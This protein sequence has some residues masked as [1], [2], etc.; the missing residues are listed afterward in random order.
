MNKTRL[1]NLTTIL[2]LVLGLCFQN[3][4]FAQEKV[5]LE[6]RI[7]GS[8]FKALAKA[9]VV[10]MDFN[11]FKADNISKLSKMDEEKFQ[12]RYAKVYLVVK[13][14][15]FQIRIRY[16]ISEQM[17]R[18]EVIRDI[19]SL[20]KKQVYESIDSIPD[21]IIAKQFKQYLNEKKQKPQKSNIVGQ[22][23]QLW[24]KI[25]EKIGR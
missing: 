8:T 5:R 11:K 18:G 6:D 1:V 22:I 2:L 4:I 14:L 21:T 24:N 9:F 25:L 12:K 16:R 15:P 3:S 19:E 20:N 7:I 23:N 17:T 10:V 13:E